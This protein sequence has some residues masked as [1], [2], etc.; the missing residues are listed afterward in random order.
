MFFFG[1]LREGDFDPASI[2][3]LTRCPSFNLDTMLEF[4]LAYHAVTPLT[5][6]ECDALPVAMLARW[7]SWR[8]EGAMK[9][10]EDRRAE[11]FRYG[12][13]GPFEG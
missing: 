12:F 4:V 13:F 11:F 10:P 2:W 5:E 8:M 9:V 7:I 3:S 6:A 1:T